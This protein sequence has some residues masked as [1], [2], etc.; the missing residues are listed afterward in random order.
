MIT[1]P[2]PKELLFKMLAMLLALVLA[3]GIM[4]LIKPL[5]SASSS[6][7]F[8]Q[9]FTKPS[10]EAKAKMLDKIKDQPILFTEN[11]GQVDDRVKYYAQTGSS[12]LFFTGQGLTFREKSGFFSADFV[13]ANKDAQISATDKQ[14]AKSNYYIGNDPKNWQANVSN[15][16]SITYRGLYPGI[17]LTYKSTDKLKYEYNVSPKADPSQIKLNY[18]GVKSLKLNAKGDLIIKSSAATV[19]DTKPF[20]YQIINGKKVA[21]DSKYTINKNTVGFEIG[22]YNTGLPLIIDPTVEFFETIITAGKDMANS[23]DVDSA[24]NFYVT[25][26]TYVEGFLVT[27]GSTLKGS[28][29]VFVMKYSTN[30]N[31]IYSTFI[32][33]TTEGINTDIGNGIAVDSQGSAY[34]TGKTFATDFPVTSNF[35]DSSNGGFDA[36]LL[37]LNQNGSINF[38]TYVGGSGDDS[39]NSIAVNSD[40]IYLTGETNSSNFPL[41]NPYDTFNGNSEVFISKFNIAGGSPVFS[42]H[43]GGASEEQG[44]GITVDSSGNFYVAGVTNSTDFTKSNA[45]DTLLG[46]SKDAFVIKLNSSNSLVYA[47]YLGGS[48][49]D[50][51]QSI[52]ADSSGNA[53]VTGY[54]MSNDFPIN[55]ASD[56]TLN[57]SYDAFVSKLNPTGASLIYSTYYGYGENSDYAYGIDVDNS[58]RAFVSVRT[59]DGYPDDDPMVIIYSSSGSEIYSTKLV[60]DYYNKS[61]YG[62]AIALDSSGNP[63]IAGVSSSY[64][65]K[66]GGGFIF[67]DDIFYSKLSLVPV[68][69]IFTTPTANSSSVQWNFIDISDDETGFILHDPSNSEKGKADPGANSFTEVSLKP[70]TTY[71]RHIHSTNLFGESVA[72]AD[73]TVR[74]LAN[75]PTGANASDGTFTDRIRVSWNTS[76]GAVSYRV[77]RNGPAGVGTLEYSG[78][79]TIFDDVNKLDDSIYTYYVYAVNTPGVNSAGYTSDTGYLGAAIPAA[80]AI[81]NI[82]TS[83]LSTSQIRWAFTDNADN[84]L[85]FKLHDSSNVT[86]TSS[87]NPNLTYLDENGLSVN[88]AHTRHVH[89]YTEAADSSPSANI[90]RY[91]KIENPTSNNFTNVTTSSIQVN[92]TSTFSNLSSGSSGLKFRNVTNANESGW[93]QNTNWSTAS[94]APNTQ[95]A[96]SITSRNGDGVSNSVYNAGSVFTL[97]NTPGAPN[98]SSPSSN[99]LK[100]VVNT[101]GNPS[102]TTYSIYNS[103]AAKYLQADG[104][105]G[106][107]AFFRTF[108]EWGGINGV[109][110]SGLNANIAYSYKVMAQNGDGA[111]TIFGSDSSGSTTAPPVQPPAGQNPVTNQPVTISATGLTLAVSPKS[112][113]AGKA[114]TIKG[115]LKDASGKDVVGKKVVLKQKVLKVVKKKVK[116][117]VK[118]IK[119]WIW[120]TIANLTTDSNGNFAKKLKPK[121]TTIYKAEY[122]GDTGYK[123]ASSNVAK[124]IVKKAKKK[125]K[126]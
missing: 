60:V 25:G 104:S 118:I 30:G 88:T 18:K 21:V 75:N 58:G 11:K 43:H 117:K 124:V 76:Q 89:A 19:T 70:N 32:G 101:S 65:L 109:T 45:R 26:E 35:D 52:A 64:K 126:K 103:T 14:L 3:L 17:D 113:K 106:A 84:E 107:S 8:S 29:D 57:G 20:T 31:R 80:P 77:Y 114:V 56:S 54:T 33:G 68:A 55:A 15:F 67:Y 1:L 28:S 122:V 69:P 34:V 85:G 13:G 62:K 92:A 78:S 4:P 125:K 81:E 46:G 97:A 74:T 105:L 99:S 83:A 110:N 22:A 48:N 63:Y 38:S 10:T 59:S 87:E 36:F 108:T 96:F 2:N 49:N 90:A 7:G 72:S 111:A 27:D 47:T 53:Y 5:G 44:Y 9:E 16:S 98:V 41:N 82:K 91:T 116:G 120:K 79:A 37:K 66:A 95:Y 24:G 50:V 93:Q 119:K 39:G 61:Q 71:V 51:G 102:N 123:A 115:Q 121:A 42:T 23:I 112:I 40:Y 100:V 6:S 73:Q 94:L 86:K 12:S